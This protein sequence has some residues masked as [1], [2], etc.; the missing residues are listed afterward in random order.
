VLKEI[1]GAM[2]VHHPGETILKCLFDEPHDGEEKSA[3]N[4]DFM[5]VHG[6]K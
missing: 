3:Q 5:K 2:R 6:S 4:R 1:A